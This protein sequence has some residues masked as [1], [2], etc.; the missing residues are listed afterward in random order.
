MTGLGES[1]KSPTEVPMKKFLLIL[2]FP[3]VIYAQ[4]KTTAPSKKVNAQKLL[5]KKSNVDINKIFNAADFAKLGINTSR[6]FFIHGNIKGL[7]DSTLV[8][9][10]NITNG[11]TIAQ[12]YAYNG[13]I[14]LKGQLDNEGLYSIGFIGYKNEMQIFIGNEDISVTG[15]AANLTKLTVQGSKMEDDFLYYQKSYVTQI[16]QLNVLV[17]KITVEKNEKTKDSLINIYKKIVIVKADKF[18]KEKPASPIAAFILSGL[19]G[20]FTTAELESRFNKLAPEAQRGTYAEL[21]RRKLNDL[22]IAVIGTTAPDFTQNDTSGHPVML[23][24][25]RGKYVLVDFW[26]SWCQPCM[27]E[28]PN[29]IAVFQKYQHK[30]FTILG[31]SLDQ[32]KESW[33]KAIKEN[34]LEWVQVSDLQFWNN[35]VLKLYGI[36]S[37]PQNILIAPDG[38]IIAKNLQGPSLDTKLNEVL[39]KD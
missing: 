23:S 1:I 30:N 20:L 15:D 9:I 26:A 14:N 7:K 39:M 29:L 5:N 10:T 11:N 33:V 28:I 2:L 22:K 17:K 12:D 36:E 3:V 18:L 34:R 31:V 19:A 38:K 27:I 4:N 21:I 8:F 37:I 16:D 13:A 24:S 32:Y 35:S 6:G 25:L